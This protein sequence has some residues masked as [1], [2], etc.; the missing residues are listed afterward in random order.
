MPNYT[1]NIVP[2]AQAGPGR[3]SRQLSRR[4]IFEALL[5][6]GPISRAD[7]AKVTGLSKQTTSEVIDGFEQQGIVRP[8]GRTSGNVGRTAVLYEL[9][10]EGGHVLGVD[11]GATNLRV[12]IADISSRVL[13]EAAEPTNPEGGLRALDQIVRLANRLARDVGSHPRRIRSIVVATPGRVNPISGAIELAPNIIGLNQFDVVGLLSDKLGRPVRIENDVN[14][15]LLGEI[16]HGCAQGVANVALISL[17]TG[18]GLGLS[19]DGHLVRGA[20]GAAGEIGY[21]PIAGDLSTP[22]ARNQGSLEYE[23]AAGGIIRRY[24]SAGGTSVE[25]IPTLFK[26][27]ERGDVIATAVINETAR[28]MGLTAAI[29]VATV[30]PQL[31]VLG[32]SVGGRSGF[33][34]RVA[35]QLSLVCTRSIEIRTSKLGDRATITGALAVALGRLHEDLFGIADL[36]GALAL[37]APKPISQTAQ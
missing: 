1:K 2:S 12:A 30:D 36:H 9:S 10:P 7:L 33:A 18:I 14:L 4:S 27:M 29:V 22:E 20:H 11:L 35:E 25:N 15:A 34:A 28:L 26:R 17:G 23:M 3:V 24:K 19:V 16:W 32:G 6:K 5:H 37:P 31:L 13:C 21:L 8:V